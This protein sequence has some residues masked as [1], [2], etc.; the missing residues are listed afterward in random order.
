MKRSNTSPPRGTSEE[1]IVKCFAC[2]KKRIATPCDEYSWNVYDDNEHYILTS[3]YRCS[4]KKCDRICC[5]DCADQEV[6]TIL[7]PDLN[8]LSHCSQCERV[9]CFK[10]VPRMNTSSV[11]VKC[12]PPKMNKTTKRAVYFRVNIQL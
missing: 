1:R 12:E 9:W 11:C 3:Y 10:C 2:N 7:H 8:I 4:R 5:E 6:D